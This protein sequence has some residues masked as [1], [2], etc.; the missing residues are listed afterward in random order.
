MQTVEVVQREAWVVCT[1][2]EADGGV[3]YT[4]DREGKLFFAG[5]NPADSADQIDFP[6]LQPFECI[7]DRS[8]HETQ[9]P[10]VDLADHA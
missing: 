2:D 5:G 8:R 1:R 3:Q 4:I 10:A 6:G 9:L 7:V